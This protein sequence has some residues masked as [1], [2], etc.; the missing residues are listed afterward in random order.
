M[1][2]EQN[3]KRKLRAILSADV[4]GHSLL[5]ADNEVFTIRTL[6][7]YREIMAELILDSFLKAG[8]PG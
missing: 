1:P 8:L 6:K 5:M 7:A 3:V 2:N 4:K